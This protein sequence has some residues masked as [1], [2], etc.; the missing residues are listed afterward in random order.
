M[1]LKYRHTICFNIIIIIML[2]TLTIV[3]SLP[4]G[5]REAPPT[6]D[7]PIT[8]N[9]LLVSLITPTENSNNL[10]LLWRGAFYLSNENLLTAEVSR[11]FMS[12]YACV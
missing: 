1:E 3:H 7:Q 11:L 10:Y 4:A 12:L 2:N 6:V 5:R 9:Q 8:L